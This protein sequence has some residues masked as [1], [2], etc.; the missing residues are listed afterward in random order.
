LKK[1]FSLG[2]MAWMMVGL[3]ACQTPAASESES[4]SVELQAL[5]E[6]I[7]TLE[8]END[9]LKAALSATQSSEDTVTFVVESDTPLVRTMAFDASE[10]AEPMT[11]LLR[12]LG[13]ENVTYSESEFGIFIESIGSM[14]PD[15]GSYIM[16]ERN[17]T[18]LSVGFAEA[19]I[20]DGDVF[21]FSLVY[22]DLQAAQLNESIEHFKASV[23]PTYISAF[24]YDVLHAVA[25][26][27]DALDLS[28]VAR[29]TDEI[30]ALKDLLILKALGDDISQAARVYAEN[31][32][33]TVLFRAS[34]GMMALDGTDAY[35]SVLNAYM[36]RVENLEISTVS[37]D[38]LA[39]TVMHLKDETPAEIEAAW[40]DQLTML[41]NAPSLAFAILSL[42]AMDENPY[43]VTH[44]EG[45]SLP[46]T[47]M[48]LQTADGGFLYDFTSGPLSTQQFSSPQ[49]FLALSAL[50]AYL[51][52]RPAVP[53][54]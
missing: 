21:R 25:L 3:V 18:P 20:E 7:E 13:E 51:N 35:D 29:G 34:L 11:L 9:T 49:S 4:L 41:N 52:A 16:I 40:R 46:E 39:M 8:T 14:V 33:T 42:I 17:N 2:L 53:Y 26:N 37:F 30:T 48:Q 5:Q 54:E 44:Q 24:N 10:S 19:P 38:D 28:Y 23:G 27:Q 36:T 43:D 15:Y 50:H 45:L 31:F 6:R 47:L 22:W 1:L 32:E 12:A